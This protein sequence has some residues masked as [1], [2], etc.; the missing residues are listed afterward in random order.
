MNILA[1]LPIII[2]GF[3]FHLSIQIQCFIKCL[4][5]TE[6][7]KRAKTIWLIIIVIFNVFG[8]ISYFLVTKKES[9]YYLTGTKNSLNLNVRQSIFLGLLITFEFLSVA[10]ITVNPD[11]LIIIGLLSIAL[12]IL[13][14][15]YYF[16]DRLNKTL[17]FL[18]PILL[19]AAVILADYFSI[20]SDYKII[21]IVAVAI[22]IIEY[23][24][25]FSKIFFWVPLILYQ[26]AAVLKLFTQQGSVP[27][28]F[29]IVFVAKNSI[30]YIL[31]VVA[32]YFVKKHLIMNHHLKYVMQELKNKTLELEEASIIKERNRIAREIHDTLGHTLTGA[33]IQL[34]VAKKMVYKDQA[35]T[36]ETIQKVQDITRKGFSELKR[37]IKALHPIMIEDNT[38]TDG[39]TLLFKSVENDFNYTVSYN[40]DIPEKISD[41][42]KVSV[43]RIIQEIITNGIRHGGTNQMNLSI[44]YQFGM[45][46]I[47]SN[48]NGKGCKVINEGN[49]LKGIRERVEKLNGQAFFA[50]EK[51]KGFCAVI[52]IPL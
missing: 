27:P 2:L 38:L 6:L 36:V 16:A 5:N 40:I 25:K 49:G 4:N 11:N 45:L 46:R 42:V 1:M 22:I 28:D 15:V 9:A 21:V 12:I 14:A 8:V 10:I 17:K 44:E 29:L 51:G 26:G 7:N 37:A 24:L 35:E 39:L 20:N 50:S 19:A 33:I 18:V 47:N 3:C 23:P 43:Y 32:F 30:T 52:N 13:A 41:F 31:V 48:D 34:E